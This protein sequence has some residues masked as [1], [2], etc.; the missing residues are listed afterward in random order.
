MDPKVDNWINHIDLKVDKWINPKVNKYSDIVNP[1]DPKFGLP[2]LLNSQDLL[3]VLPSCRK[4]SLVTMSW[5]PPPAPLF[6]L[7]P[8]PNFTGYHQVQFV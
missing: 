7:P 8:S 1:I 5:I 4:C 3:N 6:P 2:L